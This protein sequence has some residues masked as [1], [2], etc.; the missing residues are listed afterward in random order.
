MIKKLLP[1][2]KSVL[3]IT[4]S[5]L[6]IFSSCFSLQA[7][8]RYSCITGKWSDTKTWATA[9]N[10][11][12]GASIP[13]SGDTVYIERGRTVTIDP[14]YSAFCGAIIIGTTQAGSAKLQFSLNSSLT[15]SGMVQ[16]G[17][18]VGSIPEA[19]E[20]FIEFAAGSKMSVS[21]PIIIGNKDNKNRGSFDF[22]NG[23]LLQIGS[24]ITVNFM[25]KFTAGTGTVEY[26]GGDQTIP[27]TNLLGTYNN[28]TLSGT[29]IKTISGV[30]VKGVLSMEGA[31]TV[32]NPSI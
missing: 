31:A 15:V 23:G 11:K 27:S 2:N 8:K 6:V 29:G 9:S 24:T 32:S 21:G 28:L 10:G 18:A 12:A 4:A 3:I 14:G 22:T 7:A 30:N 25:G 16:V 19:T 5:L 1:W 20:G 13:T 17:G 26:N